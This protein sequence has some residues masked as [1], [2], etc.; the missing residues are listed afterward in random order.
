MD[1]N[2]TLTET[3]VPMAPPTG[4]GTVQPLAPPKDVH[5]EREEL[6][7][8]LWLNIKNADRELDAFSHTVSQDLRG[9][10]R[11]ISVSVH[12]VLTNHD[13][14]LEPSSREQ[15]IKIGETVK[16]MGLVIDSMLRLS[17][18]TRAEMKIEELDMSYLSR[19]IADETLERYPDKN[20]KFNIQE[21]VVAMGD[22]RLV[23]AVFEK[24]LD[25]ACE[26]ACQS[27][28]PTVDVGMTLVNNKKAYWV[29]DNGPGFPPQQAHRIFEPTD[30]FG[31]RQSAGMGLSSVK[32]II[33]RHGGKVWAQSQ[34]GHGAKFS[35]TLGEEAEESDEDE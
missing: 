27:A 16:H 30:K 2:P 25:N 26:S 19:Q 32:R 22:E 28:G 1:V 24:L 9:Q 17:A 15:L 3:G 14:H 35:F 21:N 7:A 29:K 33:E 8:R 11:G 13:N 31:N 5:V 4:A 18:L 20:I 12:E 6:I 10:L 23:T 34:P